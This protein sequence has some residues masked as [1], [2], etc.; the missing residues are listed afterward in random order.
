M[1]EVYEDLVTGDEVTYRVGRGFATGTFQEYLEGDMIRLQTGT[2]KFVNRH[3]SSIESVTRATP[4][5]AKKRRKKAVDE[6]E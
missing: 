2:G 4:A 5:P 3:F 1:A 6:A